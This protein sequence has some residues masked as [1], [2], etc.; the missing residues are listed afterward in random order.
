MVEGKERS[1]LFISH[2]NPEDNYFALWLASKL[3]ML[4]Y[5]VWVDK[6]AIKHGSYFTLDY[7]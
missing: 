1:S 7:E 4:G 3:A 5:K 2:A 6:R